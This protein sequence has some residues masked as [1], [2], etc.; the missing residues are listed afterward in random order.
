M[1]HFLQVHVLYLGAGQSWWFAGRRDIHANFLY[2]YRYPV[3]YARDVPEGE[4]QRVWLF[5][6]PI[7]I[8]RRPGIIPRHASRVSSLRC[9]TPC[10]RRSIT[11]LKARTASMWVGGLYRFEYC[12]TSR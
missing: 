4:P 3:H 8:A 12:S 5:D 7:V 11:A 6:E 9:T 2:L 10:E 1:W